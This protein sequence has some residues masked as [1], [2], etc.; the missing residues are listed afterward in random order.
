MNTYD[1]KNMSIDELIQKLQEAK[2]HGFIGK[3]K[4]IVKLFDTTMYDIETID[5]DNR[6]IYI[7]V[8]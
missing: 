3:E 7:N 2:E 5:F 8:Y 1:I 6:N 4:V